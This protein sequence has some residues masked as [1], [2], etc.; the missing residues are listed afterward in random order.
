[1][2]NAELWN[3]IY[4]NVLIFHMV[5]IQGAKQK[6]KAIAFFSDKFHFSRDF[7]QGGGPFLLL[8]RFNRF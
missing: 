7:P 4:K 3:E 8:S 6:V 5:I 2:F 1:M